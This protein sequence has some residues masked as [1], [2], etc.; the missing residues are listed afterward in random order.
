MLN[1][2]WL[3]P[4]IARGLYGDGTCPHLKVPVRKEGRSCPP[5]RIELF[6]ELGLECSTAHYES[7]VLHGALRVNLASLKMRLSE[8]QDKETILEPHWQTTAAPLIQIN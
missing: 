1:S 3:F 6:Q 8:F 5:S 4:V 2:Y 7:I